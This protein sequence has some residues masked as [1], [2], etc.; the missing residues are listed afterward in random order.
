V[1]PGACVSTPE[2]TLLSPLHTKSSAT[3]SPSEYLG[4][5][6]VPLSSSSFWKLVLPDRQVSLGRNFSLH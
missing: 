3:W 5:L 2:E 1:V 6:I 4:D